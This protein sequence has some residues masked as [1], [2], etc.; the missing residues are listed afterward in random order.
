[1]TPTPQMILHIG[2]PKC[3]SSALQ[4]ALSMTPDLRSSDGTHYRYTAA[5]KLAGGWRAQ[6]GSTLTTGARLSPYGYASWPDFLPTHDPAEIFGALKQTLT[7]GKK[8]NY[9]PIASSE[10]WI[11]RHSAFAAALAEWGNP[12]V[13]VVI[14]LRPPIDWVNA[15]FW[16]WG[17]WDQPELDV[18]MARSNM[19]YSF[20]GDIAAWSRIPNVNMTVRSQRPDVVAKFAG[21]YDLPLSAERQSN[22]ASPATLAGVLLRNR[23]FRPSGH[24]GA[25]EF[26]VQRWCPPVP[27]R[28]LWAVLSRHVQALRPVRLAALETLREV[29][30]PQDQEDLFSD[31]RWTHE[32]FYHADILEGVTRLNDPVLFEPLYHALYEGVGAAAQAAGKSLPSLPPC[33]AADADI[34]TWDRALCPLLETLQSMDAAVRRQTVPWWKRVAFAYLSKL[35]AGRL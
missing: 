21:L 7:K 24:Q 34:A 30:S 35:R 27:G 19:S 14:F 16:Q 12:P 29:L 13:D 6:E 2:A 33:P 17:I 18:W 22:T 31:P 28:K 32:V 23:A 3:G 10:G 26:V 5:H 4:T 8:R 25:I 11:S 1:M 20:A 15:A 9:I